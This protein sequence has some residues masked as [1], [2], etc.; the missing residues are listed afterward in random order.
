MDT[1][2]L[3]L[4]DIVTRVGA[5]GLG[6][7]LVGLNRN[8]HHQGAGMRTFGLVALATGGI[9]VGMLQ[10]GGDPGSLSRTVQ[11]VL[12]GIGFLGGGVIL[13]RSDLGRVTGLT[14]A[15]AIWFVAGN[16]VL[17]ALGLWAL[18]AVLMSFAFFLLLFG[19]AVEEAMVRWFGAA[20]IDDEEHGA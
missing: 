7:A 18:T 13:R 15:A 17:C 1:N 10:V 12:A 8:L 9:T 11:G 6:G 14:S 5:A 20:E 2:P 19:R 3:T 4:L 16:A